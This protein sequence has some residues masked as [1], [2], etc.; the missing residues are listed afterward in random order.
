MFEHIHEEMKKL[1]AH[2]IERIDPMIVGDDLTEFFQKTELN[3]YAGDRRKIAAALKE[4]GL[5][6]KNIK[7]ENH[8]AWNPIITAVTYVVNPFLPEETTFRYV[9]R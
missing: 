8:G 3:I 5:I 6:I 9:W 4:S 2:E 7:H 1:Y